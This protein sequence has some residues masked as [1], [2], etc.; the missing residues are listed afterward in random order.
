[1]PKRKRDEPSLDALFAR[2]RGDLFH[3]LKTAKGH[4]RQ[5]QSK[6]L[7]DKKTDP[8]KRARIENEVVVLK[9][10]DL[11][12]TAHA[13]LCS[14]LLRLKPVAAAG[15]RLPEALRAGVPKPELTDE[16]RALLHNVTSALYNRPEVKRVVEKAVEEM[17]RA[18]GVEVPKKGAGKEKAVRNG[19]DGAT[20]SNVRENKEK[21]KAEDA[22]NG[23]E[24]GKKKK[25]KEKEKEKKDKK[26]KKDDDGD[27]AAEESKEKKSK[28]KSEKE[29][30]TSSGKDE[31][32]QSD[33][34]EDEIDEE[35]EEKAV[36]ELDKLLGL[37]S[38]EESGSDEEIL[39]KGRS[40]KPSAKE[41]DPME[42]T[43]EE[44]DDNSND[45]EDSEEDSDEDGASED[46]RSER[47]AKAESSDDFFDFSAAEKED[48]TSE[49]DE[50]SE[51]DQDDSDND[52]SS[53]GSR[54]PPAKRPAT[55]KQKEKRSGKAESVW[56]LPALMTG[57]I[58]GSESASEID[59]A[60]VRK[61]RRGQRARQAIWEK[62]YGDKAR[63]LQKQKNAR[64]EGWD[65][66]R[67]AVD[68]GAK[69]WKK[70]I[71]NPLLDKGKKDK[72]AAADGGDSGQKG[73][74]PK[75]RTNG[76][77]SHAGKST[78]K[79]SK[80][81][82]GPPPKKPQRARD[83]TGPLHPSWEAKRKAKEQ[84]TAPFQGKKI[85]FD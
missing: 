84:L 77:A 23:S 27:V 78:S 47:S 64:D 1:M 4:E 13:H 40:R 60:P 46:D 29:S 16:E 73:G 14:S 19:G 22:V 74:N 56:A 55:S 2:L 67:G 65:L 10:L 82:Q 83:D 8:A 38:D 50:T 6:R 31:K 49:D 37:G 70:G 25:V 75:G 39:I 79:D 9:S 26:S 36:A 28:T 59:E 34:G 48:S 69:P 21:T 3:A 24:S 62:K 17:C 15:D 61:N 11:H 71:R 54:S 80:P 35:D 44:E 33:S 45:D 12:Q 72:D 63:H 43:T 57:Y 41:L 18:L 32:P 30:G 68:P 76:P 52:S 20:D 42:I 58:S 53:S 81:S 5:R 7:K 66:K 51:S 85:T